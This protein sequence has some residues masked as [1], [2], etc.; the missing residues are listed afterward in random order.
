MILTCFSANDDA[1]SCWPRHVVITT[2]ATLPAA[3]TTQRRRGRVIGAFC[4][5]T[6]CGHVGARNVC[7]LL[8]HHTRLSRPCHAA[9]YV[10][11]NCFRRNKM[12]TGRP[13]YRKTELSGQSALYSTY[14]WRFKWEYYII[15]LDRLFA[16]LLTVWNSVAIFKHFIRCVDCKTY[17]FKWHGNFLIKR[18]QIVEHFSISCSSIVA[19]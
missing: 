12:L 19:N 2:W 14:F 1:L 8:L 16:S 4:A 10:D 3:Y 9:F 7:S 13:V 18:L 5:T 17:Q 6:W 11:V 15:N